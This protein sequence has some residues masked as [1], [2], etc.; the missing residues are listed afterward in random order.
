MLEALAAVPD[1][2]LKRLTLQA[3]MAA[4]VNTGSVM[5]IDEEIVRR[6]GLN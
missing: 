2:D 3:S 4:L 1:D 6:A 5:A